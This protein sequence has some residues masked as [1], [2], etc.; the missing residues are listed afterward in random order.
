MVSF[1]AEGLL[2]SSSSQDIIMSNPQA[3]HNAEQQAVRAW[4]LV[5][6]Q[7][8]TQDLISSRS[9]RRSL[10]FSA[11]PRSPST[12]EIDQK[13]DTESV[14]SSKPP[15]LIRRETARPAAGL[16][17]GR[18]LPPTPMSAPRNTNNPPSPKVGPPISP[19]L[20]HHPSPPSSL[21]P[22]P[23]SQPSTQPP[24]IPN[25]P[26][27][28]RRV[29]TQ[30]SVDN[31]VE[32]VIA[33]TH[34][35]SPPVPAR[36]SE[37][38]SISRTSSTNGLDE[39]VS[40]LQTPMRVG[41]FGRTQSDVSIIVNE[42]RLSGNSGGTSKLEKLLGQGAGDPKKSIF[43][44]PSGNEKK[45]EE[46][47]LKN[48]KS[49]FTIP[50]FFGKNRKSGI[51][52]DRLA[53]YLKDVSTDANTASLFNI[54]GKEIEK[55]DKWTS[56][57]RVLFDWKEV[58]TDYKSLTPDIACLLDITKSAAEGFNFEFG[59][60]QVVY[61]NDIIQLE[62]MD[63]DFKYFEENFS[64]TDHVNY[65]ADGAVSVSF[66]WESA[67]DHQSEDQASETKVMV[68]TKRKTDRF[69][70]PASASTSRSNIMKHIKST[71]P[72]FER[73]KFV[74]INNSLHSELIPKLCEYERQTVFKKYK[75]G[76]LYVKDKQ[77]EENEMFSNVDMSPDF[78]EF[79]D[80]IGDRI[81][82]EGWAN[83]RG[84]LDVKRNTTG[85]H[86]VYALY[87]DFEIMYHVSTLLPFQPDD[88][89][90]VE[91][92]RHLGNDVVQIMFK[93]GN[94]P[95]DPLTLR[96]HYNHV[97]IVVSVA[98]K[99]K[100]KT[101]YKVAIANKAGVPPFG[102]FLH[103]PPIYE[104]NEEF[105]EFLITKCETSSLS[106]LT[107]PVINGE[108]AA[109]YATDFKTKLIR[110][111][112]TLLEEMTKD[113]IQKSKEKDRQRNNASLDM[114]P[115]SSQTPRPSSPQIPNNISPNRSNAI[116]SI[117]VTG[118]EG[119]SPRR[120][121]LEGRPFLEVEDLKGGPRM[122]STM[123][124]PATKA[125]SAGQPIWELAGETK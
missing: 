37:K 43:K 79:L 22:P 120:K 94:T 95:F 89:Q 70:A 51:Y 73:L 65:M 17:G 2:E 113:F 68:R 48:K 117:E 18:S 57:D 106:Q 34:Q 96:T 80:F 56:K 101:F 123:R 109:M 59:K 119:T 44:V 63:R 103:Y 27:P 36:P 31:I 107:R 114:D 40:H 88:L 100:G 98:K 45:T 52:A 10:S 90:R 69:L 72:D 50:K 24:P 7:S 74:K 93:E 12:D 61:G 67:S 5:G 13:D 71:Y 108:R 32:A 8:E 20:A 6:A 122:V 112:K 14:P 118:T 86:S 83:F 53:E 21:P 33:P 49:T 110:T 77:T 55:M 29:T 16:G 76:V 11:L 66:I 15:P 87:K 60:N 3:P 102:P 58:Q 1:T 42:K 116:P 46:K 25:R 47:P 9:Q 92:K 23:T 99:E 85:T 64:R 28:L 125:R 38:A 81:P 124:Q 105:Y 54:I 75:F 26:P 19:R 41:A 4:G 91:R 30:R 97:F 84:G 39:H 104:K 35:S 121:S 62:D 115:P 111:N 78:E 82:L